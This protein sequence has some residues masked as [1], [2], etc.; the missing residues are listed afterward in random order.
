MYG[1]RVQ[2]KFDKLKRIKNNHNISEVII[3]HNFKAFVFLANIEKLGY[4]CAK[5]M[6]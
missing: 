4:N 3:K 2:R 6:S 5:N 1:V